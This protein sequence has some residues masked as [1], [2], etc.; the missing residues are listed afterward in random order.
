[1]TPLKQARQEANRRQAS[2]DLPASGATWS[3]LGVL[4]EKGRLQR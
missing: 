3:L 1:M 2:Q 4:L